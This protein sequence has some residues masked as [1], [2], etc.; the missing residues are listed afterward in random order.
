MVLSHIWGSHHDQAVPRT[1]PLFQGKVV[2]DEVTGEPVIVATTSTQLWRWVKLPVALV[3]SLLCAGV[4]LGTMAVFTWLQYKLSKHQVGSAALGVVNGATM[5]ALTSGLDLV[6]DRITDWQNFPL[7]A[8]HNQAAFLTLSLTL[9]LTLT[10]S[11]TIE[12]PNPHHDPRPRA[13]PGIHS[14]LL[15]TSDAADEEDSVDLGGRRIIKK[16]KR[17]ETSIT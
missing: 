14:C 12:G 17:E 7:E 4:V 8:D 13:H 3:V 9:T 5:V 10:R 16:K 1:R 2:R 15:Y 11:L 6:A